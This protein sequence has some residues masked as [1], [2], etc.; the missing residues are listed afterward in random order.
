MTD[1][2]IAVGAG[3]DLAEVL[4]RLVTTAATL[5]R[6]RY[7]AL[8]ITGD[9]GQVVDFI[10]HGISRR[11]REQLGGMPGAHGIPG[12]LLRPGAEPLRLD[13]IGDHP[14]SV[15]FPP[16]HPPMR[17]FLGVPVRVS[18]E[19]F[20]NLYVADKTSV[21][22]GQA[23]FTAEDE[24]AL[25]ALGAAAGVAIE[26]ARLYAAARDRQR[27][28]DALSQAIHAV[29]ARSDLD[30][31]ARLAP[32]PAI[33][34]AAGQADLAVL[35]TR[36]TDTGWRSRFVDPDGDPAM[37][38]LPVPDTLAHDAGTDSVVDVDA[39]QLAWLPG[40]WVG[41]LLIPIG[42]TY[43]PPED[44][45]LLAY[46]RQP[47]RSL[48]SPDHSGEREFGQ[49]LGLAVQVAQ[50]QADSAALALLRDRDRIARDL[51][52]LVIQRLFAVGLSLQAAG[53]AARV[54]EVRARLSRAVDDLDETIK[55]VR[56][57]I[58]ELHSRA[59]DQTADG[60]ASTSLRQ[61][62]QDIVVETADH[63]GADIDVHISG[64]VD[65]VPPGMGVDL[66]AVLREAL[67]NVARHA[68]AT[69][70][71]IYLTVGAELELEVVDDGAGIPE[72]PSP[73]E[74]LPNLRQRAEAWGGALELS[75]ASEGGTVMRWAVPLP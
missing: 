42:G 2:V 50:A 38:A 39:T 26:N 37:L 74:G 66:L 61:R 13:A 33:A 1:A 14:A 8:G 12:L 46:R 69:H 59:A 28:S 17:T 23:L 56:R 54:P 25:L 51:H 58:F 31:R 44:A 40:T 3:L 32:I 71:H 22:G 60:T 10:T 64:A 73:G 53:V 9:G 45:V 19:I 11:L 36:G 6:A 75:P 62:V 18:G 24:E 49:R 21:T 55:D 15:G 63:V 52:D 70:V 72:N 41:A 43:A 16:D 65:D 35:V 5:S 47:H 29:I 27:W 30:T 20:G 48:G 4:Q 34:R 68:A 7:A 57:T 67:T